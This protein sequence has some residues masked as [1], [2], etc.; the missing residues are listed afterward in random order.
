MS[1]YNLETNGKELKPKIIDWMG[2]NDYT[3]TQIS[4]FK[5][6]KDWRVGTTMG[7]IAACLLKGMPEVHAGFNHGKNTA[8]WLREQIAKVVLEGKDDIEVVEE[9]KKVKVDVYVPTIQDR[10]REAAGNMTEE[11]DAAI[12]T[13]ITDPDAFDPKAFKVVSLL[14]GKGVK[15]AHARVI[16]G[17]Y[18]RAIAEYAEL[19]TKDCDEQLMEG[20]SHYGKKNIKKMAD[21]LASIIDA[22]D[23]IAAEAKVLKKPRAKKVKPAEELVKKIKFKATDDRFGIASIPAAQIIGAQVVVV[24][25]TKT[26]KMGVYTAKTSGGLEVKGAS[27]TNFTDKSCQKTL[28]K[29]ELQIKEFKDLNTAKRLQTW[30]D[31]IKTTG[32]VLNG[33]INAEV[34]ILKAWK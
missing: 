27:I 24:F 8:V 12:D 4:D 10:L 11:L 30:F 7:A 15:A 13:Y 19:Q 5:K 1:W 34:M 20:Y 22:C 6:T 29:P 28:R 25:N 33:R 16:K 21:F 31:G 23:Q 26:R 9:A 2:R 32:T 17:F 3:R 18:E 14:R